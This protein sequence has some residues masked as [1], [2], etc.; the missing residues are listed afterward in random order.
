MLDCKRIC[1]SILLAKSLSEFHPATR[2]ACAL[3][4]L[5]PKGEILCREKNTPMILVRQ[6]FTFTLGAL[7]ARLSELGGAH[8]QTQIQYQEISI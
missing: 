3:K 1:G 5:V 2:F 4:P 8:T 7:C 6:D